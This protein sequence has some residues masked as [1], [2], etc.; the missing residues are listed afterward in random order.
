MTSKQLCMAC[1]GQ[2]AASQTLSVKHGVIQ[3]CDSDDVA[4]H[5]LRQAP[6][7]CMVTSTEKTVRRGAFCEAAQGTEEYALPRQ[8][9]ANAVT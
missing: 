7:T 9:A 4:N 8:G 2:W 3:G 1:V 5:F 6:E